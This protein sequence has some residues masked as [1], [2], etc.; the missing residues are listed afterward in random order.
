[1][2]GLVIQAFVMVGLLVMSLL[3][4]GMA[5]EE[6]P[7]ASPNLLTLPFG[8]GGHPRHQGPEGVQ[9]VL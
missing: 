1:M 8:V 6:A 5:R 9:R 3:P 2:P 4:P 7:P